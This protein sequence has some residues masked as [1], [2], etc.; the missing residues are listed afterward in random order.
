METVYGKDVT[1]P[2]NTG[3]GSGQAPAIPYQ[4]IGIDKLQICGFSVQHIDIDWILKNE[5]IQTSQ[6]TAKNI[7]EK[8][9]DQKTGRRVSKIVIKDN[10]LF[11]DL[12]MGCCSKQGMRPTEYVYLTLVIKSAWGNLVPW[13]VREYD[14]HINKV[15]SYIKDKYHITLG[16]SN[17]KVRYMEINCNIPLSYSYKNYARPIC[18]LIS[19]VDNHLRKLSS[20]AELERKKTDKELKAE[21]FKRWNES[22]EVIFYDKTTQLEETKKGQ[23]EIKTPILRLEYRLKTPQK[24]KGVFKTN[25]WDRL[26]D[27][28]VADYFLSYSRKQMTYRMQ[29]WHEQRRKDLARLVKECREKSS[30]SWHWMLMKEVRNRSESSGIPY[31]LDIGQVFEAMRTIPDK[32]RSRK[33]KTLS[34]TLVENDVYNSQNLDKAR[35][36][37]NGIETAYENTRLKCCRDSSDEGWK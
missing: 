5:D 14:R 17:I 11:S 10:D 22:M 32:N 35:E 33:I 12:V 19:M 31:I 7:P 13:G 30:R 16:R 27:K 4:I 28:M 18:L 20:C 36:I 15:I 8:Y 29:K 2:G 34:K 1:T 9:M 6:T 23:A 37:L 26:T 3:V 21:T 24:I 25:E